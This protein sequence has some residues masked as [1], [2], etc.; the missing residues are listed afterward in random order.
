MKILCI[1]DSLSLPGHG[2]IYEDTW[3]YKLKKEFIEL[4]FISIF[5]RSL[6]TKGLNTMG[7]SKDMIYGADNLEFYNPKIVILQMG[8]VDCA[9][10]LIYEHAF[11][12]RF[13]RIMPS[14]IVNLYVKYLKKTKGRDPKNVYVTPKEFEANLELYFKRC[15][16]K[17]VE[18]LIYIAIPYPSDEMV[19]KNPRIIENVV[20]YNNIIIELS[21]KFDFIEILKPLD[22]RVYN[23][24]YDDGYHPNPKG[25]LIVFDEL[26]DV[27]RTIKQ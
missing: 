10:R 20:N 4:D 1:G 23:D 2:N 9:P 19:I 15:K 26:C 11:A 24:I 18:K 21:N 7:L 25:N 3:F 27:I 14:K 12:W 8:I 22:D 13:I 16:L 5:Q 6:T 17:Q